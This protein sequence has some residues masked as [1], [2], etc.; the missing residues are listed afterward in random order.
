VPDGF[1]LEVSYNAVSASSRF[2][3]GLIEEAGASQRES[4]ALATSGSYTY[5]GIIHN[6]YAYD[7]QNRYPNAPGLQLADGVSVTQLSN[8]QG[9]GGSSVVIEMDADSN[10]S[11]SVDGQP[12]TTGTIGGAGFD[13]TRR[14]CFF[15]RSQKASIRNQITSVTLTVPQGAPQA[16]VLLVR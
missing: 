5:R 14:Y 2:T 1:R 13:L 6:V 7:S 9:N 11:Y 16:A 3:I 15:T 4:G 12:P 8:A 10:W